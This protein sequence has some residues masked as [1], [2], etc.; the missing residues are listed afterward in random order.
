MFFAAVGWGNLYDFNLFVQILV[1]FVFVVLSKYFLE[2]IISV[3]FHLE[4]FTEQFHFYKH[5]YRS[6]LGVIL[7]PIV[8]IFYFNGMIVTPVLYLFIG[9]IFSINI[10]LY[11]NSVWIFRTLIFPKFYYFILYLC[12]LEMAPFYLAYRFLIKN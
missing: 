10:A 1:L 3:T 7:L 12:A 2:N 8:A 6:Y 9:L 11:I 4:D 5:S